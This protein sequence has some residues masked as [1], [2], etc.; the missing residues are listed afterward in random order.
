MKRSMLIAVCVGL[1][2]MLGAGN[3]QAAKVMKIGHG[4]ADSHFIGQAMHK[5]KAHVEQKT[6]G[7]IKVELYP[8]IQLGSDKEVM[9]SIKVGVA[10]MNLPSPSVVTNFVK[11]FSI[12]SLPYIFPSQKAAN[13]VADG[14]WGQSLLEKLDKA[15]FVGLGFGDFGFREMTNSVRPVEK[16]EDF[17]D[18]KIRTMQNPTHLAT[19]RALGANPTAMAWSEVFTAL[20]QGVIDGQE[21]PLMQIYTFKLNEVQKYLTLT[22]HCYDMVVFVV[23]KKWY[24]TL[25][26]GEK[27]ALQEATEIAKEHMRASVREEDAKALEGIRASGTQVTVLE[28]AEKKR[29]RDTAMVEV[30]KQGEKINKELFHSMMQAVESV[31]E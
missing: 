8:N 19:F 29:I 7:G 25:S 10:H 26:G 6:N 22:D 4:L 9:E 31:G 24:N 5:F 15:G 18:L 11:D 16:L 2:V 30:T 13:A 14:P 17:K 21:N 28:P 3:A 20:Q 27:Q 12:I 1:A 23:G